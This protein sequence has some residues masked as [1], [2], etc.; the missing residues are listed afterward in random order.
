MAKQENYIEIRLFLYLIIGF[1]C[2]NVV[3]SET[4][5]D[6]EM[7]EDMGRSVPNRCF[8]PSN[9]ESAF[10]RACLIVLNGNKT[11]CSFAWTGFKVAFGFKDPKSVTAEDYDTFFEVLPP[12]SPANSPV[13]WSGINIGNVVKEIST[14][15]KISS[16]MNQ[17]SARIIN[18]MTK[19]D[20]VMCWCGSTTAFI[21]TANPCP[22]TPVVAFWQAFSTHFA[23]SARG[24]VYFIGN[25][26]RRTGA[27]QNAS[28]FATFEFPE[29]ISDRVNKLVVID[30]YNMVEKCGEGTL[31]VLKAQAI[32]RYGIDM[33]YDCEAVCGNASNKQEISLLANQTLEII[34]QEQSKGNHIYSYVA[35]FNYL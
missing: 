6:V 2:T 30:I 13:H 16:S 4:T 11:W 29:L 15:P 26:N 28:F 27:Y 31:K 32:S 12:I 22:I 25:G 8:T 9:F 23:K 18:T 10:S 34:R 35:T 3:S 14:Q 20:N 1:L 17:V 24:I 5:T 21:D 19:D 33:G 7:M